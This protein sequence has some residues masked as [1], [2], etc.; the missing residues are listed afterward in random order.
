M[1]RNRE[2]ALPANVPAYIHREDIIP[3]SEILNTIQGEGLDFLLET[4]G[5]LAEVTIEIVNLLRPRF[6]EVRFIIP[7]MAMSAGTI[8]VMSGN[9]ILMDHRSS[10]GP[11][12]PQFA[13]PDGKL[14]PAQAIISG[15]ETI[16][17]DIA[18][19][20]GV[21]NPV[22]L[23]ILRNVDPGRLQSAI[24][25]SELST[26]LV[27]QWLTEFK[28]KNWTT[29]SSDSRPVTEDDRRSRA[30][31]IA[32]HLCS[33]Q[34]WLSH[35]RPIKIIDFEQMRLKITD[36]GKEPNLQATI[37]ALWVNLHHLLS[38]TNLY[39][40]YESDSI[41]IVKGA[42]AA[43]VGQAS[44]PA[45]PGKAMVDVKCNKCSSGYRIQCNLGA[46][47]PIEPGAEPFPKDG[48]LICRTCGT[49][50]DLSGLKLTIETQSGQPIII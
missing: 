24:N 39:K 28:F 49:L 33:H 41:D 5:G 47:Q 15:I 35:S 20:R 43:P 9:E 17:E 34:E 36:Y 40:V 38:V 30:E 37:W 29:H 27:T 2:F 48:K 26:R 32:R 23:P 42:L 11:I 3:L 44:Q 10:L 19:N 7:H 46:K 16:K 18:N 8:L 22:Y 13:G 1:P 21:L 25:A 12:D 4:P 50:L 14:Q 45:G 31:E 6:S